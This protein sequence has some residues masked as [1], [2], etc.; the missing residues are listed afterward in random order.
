M[1]TYAE[2]KKS[3]GES[4]LNVWISDK[5]YEYINEL[6]KEDL[7]TIKKSKG[8]ILD[9]ALTNLAMS[10]DCG[11]TLDMIAINHIERLSE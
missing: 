11:E 8:A 6:M 3:K 1:E 2:K 10:L 5:N 7:K 9:L 4:R